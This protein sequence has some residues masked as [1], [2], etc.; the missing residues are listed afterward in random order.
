MPAAPEA[1]VRGGDARAHRVVVRTVVAVDPALHLGDAELAVVDVLAFVERAPDERLAEPRLAALRQLAGPLAAFD[2][3]EVDVAGVPVDV[4]VGA[5]RERRDQAD[6]ALGRRQVELV[7]E[8]VLAF[9]QLELAQHRA[10]V[11]RKAKPECGESR[12]SGT[13]TSLG[14]CRTWK[15]RSGQPSARHSRPGGDRPRVGSPDSTRRK[16]M[17]RI[18]SRAPR[19]FAVM[20]LA[21]AGVLGLPGC[22]YNEFQSLDEQVSAA[23]AEVLSQYQRRSDLIPNIVATVKGEANFEQETLTRVIEARAKATSIQATPELV[24]DPAAFN[25]FQQAQGELS[26]ALSR[27][28]AVSESYPT[29]QRERRLQGPARAARRHREPHQRR[30]QQVHRRGAAVQREG[31]QRADQLHG[32]GVRL[33]DQADLHRAERGADSVPPPVSFDKPASR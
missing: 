2:E 14:P 25:K 23:W 18:L 29:L 31:A 33:Q 26:S 16:P 28:I 27:L 11:G 22:G 15:D 3:R 4:D 19:R 30:P 12:T 9:A 21:I 6:A 10:E 8:A 1:R 7:D 20:L 13:R 17:L 5:R 32:D 24:N